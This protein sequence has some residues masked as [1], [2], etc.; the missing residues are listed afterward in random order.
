MES[1][2][3]RRRTLESAPRLLQHPHR[4]SPLNHLQGSDNPR[5]S[6]KDPTNLC[7][8]NRVSGWICTQIIEFCITNILVCTRIFGFCTRIPGRCTTQPDIAEFCTLDRR[9]GQRGDSQARRRSSYRYF[10]L[11]VSGSHRRVQLAGVSEFVVKVLDKIKNDRNFKSL[12][13]GGDRAGKP[14]L[15]F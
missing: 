1:L 3:W 10:C 14:N 9:V 5:T 13:S 4:P 15:A 12:R 6:S 11:R 8:S 2:Y 7:K